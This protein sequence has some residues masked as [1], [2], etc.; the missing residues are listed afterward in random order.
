MLT[1]KQYIIE[2]Y[3]ERS[4]QQKLSVAAAISMIEK[5]CGDYLKSP[6]FPRIYRGAGTTHE[7]GFA[8]SN[9]GEA[10]K[11]ANTVNY[12]TLW[13]DN[14][15]DWEGFPK[16]S[17]SFICSSNEHYAASYGVLYRVFP[18]D[19][20]KIGVCPG[21]DLWQ[22]F[23]EFE[24][25]G[26]FLDDVDRAFRVLHLEPKTYRQLVTALD[27]ISWENIDELAPELSQDE[28][29]A[30]LEHYKA[31]SYHEIFEKVLVPRGFKHYTPRQ[32]KV[33]SDQEVYV[34]GKAIFLM[35]EPYDEEDEDGKLLITFYNKHGISSD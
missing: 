26:D 4:R 20:A 34:Q 7:A 31:N 14:H 6:G 19:D 35:Q 23:E 18:F 9:E 32:Y 13:M 12:A 22:S 30:Y 1:F 11:A 24:S 27:T 16:R 29:E 8:D 17:R 5:E 25:L 3:K 33:G 15:P 21:N 28:V 10:R 2:R